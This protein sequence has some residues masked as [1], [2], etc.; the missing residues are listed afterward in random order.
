M[1]SINAKLYILGSPV[2]NKAVIEKGEKQE[3]VAR[4]YAPLF[5]VQTR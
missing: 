4:Q 5:L 1:Q 3:A 2:R